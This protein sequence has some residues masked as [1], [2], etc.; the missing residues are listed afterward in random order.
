MT[1]GTSEGE[2]GR[3]RE[4]LCKGRDGRGAGKEGGKGEE[5][6]GAEGMIEIEQR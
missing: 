4:I 3:E 1:A 6:Q 2:G 5:T